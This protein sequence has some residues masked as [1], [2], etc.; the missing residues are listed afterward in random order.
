M[1]TKPSYLA[2]AFVLYIFYGLFRIM[3]VDTASALGGF[4]GRRIGPHLRAS[5]I[6]RKNLKH[7]LPGKSDQE[8]RQIISDMWDNL[9]RIMGEYPHLETIGKDRVEI[10]NGRILEQISSGGKGGVLFTGHLSNWEIGPV[11][12]YLQYGLKVNSIYRAPNNPFVDK[13]LLKTR[14]LGGALEPIP[15]SASGTRTIVQ[16]IKQG[17]YIGA[18]IDQKYNEGIPALLFGR[19]AMTGT[20]YAELC[21]KYGAPLVPI[22]MERLRGAHFR[23]TLFD[24]LPIHDRNGQALPIEKIVE[25]THLYLEKWIAEKPEQW[26]WIHRRWTDKAEEKFREQQRQAA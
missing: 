17:R 5:E 22:R 20:A 14:N 7:A 1:K 24:P 6:A 8:Y 26:L 11:S 25:Q 3:P 2:Q 15:K 23:L 12:T 4:I 18:L 9:G 21:L 13:L 16:E 10:C 19:P